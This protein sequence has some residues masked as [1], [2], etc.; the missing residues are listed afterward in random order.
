MPL[1]PNGL[2]PAPCD[3]D[4][5]TS[6]DARAQ[7]PTAMAGCCARMEP[8]T[9]LA[10]LSAEPR[11]PASNARRHP[12]PSLRFA[13]DGRALAASLTRVVCPRRQASP[14]DSVRSSTFDAGPRRA[15]WAEVRSSSESAKMHSCVLGEPSRRN[16]VR[17][18]TSVSSPVA[19]QC[20][21]MRSGS[22]TPP[23]TIRPRCRVIAVKVASSC[24]VH[25]KLNPRDVVVPIFG[26]ISGRTG[27]FLGTGSIVASHPHRPTPCHPRRHHAPG[28][29]RAV[30]TPSTTGSTASRRRWCSAVPTTG[31]LWQGSRPQPERKGVTLSGG[32]PGLIFQKIFAYRSSGRTF[33]QGGAPLRS[34][35]RSGVPSPSTV[36][37]ERR[38][39][40]G[41]RRFLHEPVDRQV[42]WQRHRPRGARPEPAGSQ[43]LRLRR[44][45]ADGFSPP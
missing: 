12:S 38:R 26:L 37:R 30:A 33:R 24:A 22:P 42:P 16:R 31:C 45:A 39:G 15:L 13:I 40:V 5:R 34:S 17:R 10:P 18:K 20:Q 27:P 1:G 28:P 14:R 29:I 36:A 4:R 35:H 9:S 11:C 3:N 2:S 32:F 43:Q 8:G 6:A 7:P 44:D 21:A 25:Q 19:N 23:A 41:R